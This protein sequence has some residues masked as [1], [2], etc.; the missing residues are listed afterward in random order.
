[1]EPHYAPTS[2]LS[3]EA[4]QLLSEL[5]AVREKIRLPYSQRKGD[6][7]YNLQYN[8]VGKIL[9]YMQVLEGYLRVLGT[10]DLL[11]S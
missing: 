7:S 9:A 10:Y 8:Q 2:P 11:L 3:D 6:G 5:L 1:M 4:Q